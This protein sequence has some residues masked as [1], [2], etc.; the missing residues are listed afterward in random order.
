M[1]SAR[2]WLTCAAAEDLAGIAKY[3]IETWGEE[4]LTLYRKQLEQRLALLVEFPDLGRN[5]PMLR[6]NF[7]YIVEGKHY[8]F[9]RSIAGNIEVLRFLHCRSDII[10]KLSAYL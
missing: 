2:Y 5:H 3:T 4:Q 8:I 9:Y 1:S 7:R 6:S 10:A